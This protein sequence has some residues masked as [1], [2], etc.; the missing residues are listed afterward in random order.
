MDCFL[1]YNCNKQ[2]YTFWNVESSYTKSGLFNK[3]EFTE[4]GKIIHC[5][6]CAWAGTSEIYSLNVGFDLVGEG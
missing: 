1:D 6:Y 2:R 4:Y 5:L 3:S